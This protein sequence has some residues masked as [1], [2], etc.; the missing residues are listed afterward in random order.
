MLISTVPSLLTQHCQ[1]IVKPHRTFP[2]W[3]SS[4][5]EKIRPLYGGINVI[6]E[7]TVARLLLQMVGHQDHWGILKGR[8]S[9]R[10]HT[11]THTLSSSSNIHQKPLSLCLFNMC[12]CAVLYRVISGT[13]SLGFVH[14]RFCDSFWLWSYSSLCNPG[15]FWLF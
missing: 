14:S 5:P 15:V 11:H 12:V 10:T 3:W 4:E 2:C 7:L 8:H 6:T 13:L 9:C 1:I